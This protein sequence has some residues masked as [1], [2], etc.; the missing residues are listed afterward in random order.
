ME[1]LILMGCLFIVLFAGVLAQQLIHYGI[2]LSEK[3]LLLVGKSLGFVVRVVFGFLKQFIC[4]PKHI[5][6][7]LF[8]RLFR[9]EIVPHKAHDSSDMELKAYRRVIWYLTNI[10]VRRLQQHNDF[11]EYTVKP[12]NDA[13]RSPSGRQPVE[14]E[15]T[16]TR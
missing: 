5:A 10:V 8:N 15:Y 12:A 6:L 1:L 9:K 4:I 14:I 11:G 7:W 3:S 13:P 16:R 2:L